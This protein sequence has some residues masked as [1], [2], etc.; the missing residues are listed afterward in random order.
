MIDYQVAEKAIQTYIEDNIE[1]PPLKNEEEFK[2]CCDMEWA[3]KDLLNYL[4]EFWY[5]NFPVELIADYIEDARYRAEKYKDRP[6]GKVY[7]T[8]EQ[9]AQDIALYF[10]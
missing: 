1:Y 10:V 9:T 3:A 8:A 2:H 7:K 4:K 5:Q 6:M